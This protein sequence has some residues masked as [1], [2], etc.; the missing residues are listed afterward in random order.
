MADRDVSVRGDASL[1]A[2]HLADW[3]NSFDEPLQMWGDCLAYD[4]VLFLNLWGGAGGEPKCVYYIPFDICTLLEMCNLDPDVNREEF[5][6]EGREGETKKHNA[7]SDAIIIKACY[8]M[9]ESIRFEKENLR[10]RSE[11]PSRSITEAA[12]K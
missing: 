8:S 7:L 9:L 5:A 2:D 6:Y 4:W 12:K 10:K 11:I 1:V 3:L